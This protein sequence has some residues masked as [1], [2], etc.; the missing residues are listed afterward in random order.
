AHVSGVPGELLAA[1]K[2]RLLEAQDRDEPLAARDDLERPLALLVELHHVTDRLRLPD[3][4]SGLAQQVDDRRACLLHRETRRARHRLTPAPPLTGSRDSQPGP[5]KVRAP[6]VPSFSRTTRSGNP[7]SRHH[8]TSV[9]S[10]NVQIMAIPVPFSGS[11][12]SC[13]TTGTGTPNS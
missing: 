2:E 5:P 10:P 4:P 8:V 3:E 7:S 13:A 1:A 6:I 12:S 11:A 9:I